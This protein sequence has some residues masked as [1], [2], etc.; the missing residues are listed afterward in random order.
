MC[1]V[2]AWQ[3]VAQ[4]LGSQFGEQTTGKAW[5]DTLGIS[6]VRQDSGGQ[7][8]GMTWGNPLSGCCVRAQ[9]TRRGLVWVVRLGVQGE[10]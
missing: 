7:S 2:H 4:C 9:R 6:T 10:T 1:G 8:Q 5:N 3:K